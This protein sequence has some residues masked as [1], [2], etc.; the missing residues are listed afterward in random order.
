MEAAVKA[1]VKIVSMWVRRGGLAL[2]GAAFNNLNP[3]ERARGVEI[4][5]KSIEDAVNLNC[6]HFR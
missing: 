2:K 1:N 5:K 3:A 6:A 4:I